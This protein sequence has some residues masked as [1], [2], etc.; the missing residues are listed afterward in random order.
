MIWFML[1][2]AAICIA[3]IIIFKVHHSSEPRDLEKEKK[4]LENLNYLRKNL[5]ITSDDPHVLMIDSLTKMLKRLEKLE[6]TSGR[7]L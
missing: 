5:E 3:A 7:Q 2:F 6:R 4:H 1:F